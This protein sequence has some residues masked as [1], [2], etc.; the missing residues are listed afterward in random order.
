MIGFIKKM[1]YRTLGQSAYLKA[2]HIGFVWLYKTGL[3]KKDPAYKYHYF[4]RHLVNPGDCVVDIG[5]NLGYFSSIFSGLVKANGKVISIEPVV[6]FFNT[7]RWA[8]RNKTNCTLHNKALGLENTNVTMNLP[9]LNGQF[10]TGLA[11]IANEAS[12]Q[13]DNFTFEVE[14]VKG[15]ELLGNLPAIH[16]IKCDIEGYE[17]Y[18]LPEI[19]N[20]LA[21][22]KPI[23]QIETWGSHIVPVQTLMQELGYKEY[24]IY[25]NKLVNDKPADFN[26]GDSDF[27]F[28]HS[29]AATA[30]VEKLKAI[31]AA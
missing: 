30:V 27:L 31:G 10:R 15:S 11:H 18:V 25:Q 7:L 4:V 20:I 6:P 26:F 1:M 22:H 24:R 23:L 19:K 3:L 8:L 9:K 16:F 2:L 12:N 13:Q 17:E 29:N 28:I 5:A 14:M 21:T